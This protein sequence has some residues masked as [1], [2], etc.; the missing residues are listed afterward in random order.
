MRNDKGIMGISIFLEEAHELKKSN[1]RSRQVIP[2]RRMPFHS[3]LKRPIEQKV[4]GMV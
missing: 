3:I 1:F 4:S 2:E